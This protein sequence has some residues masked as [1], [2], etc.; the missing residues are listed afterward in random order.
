MIAKVIQNV[1]IEYGNAHL[2]WAIQGCGPPWR[3]SRLPGDSDGDESHR[4]ANCES[5]RLL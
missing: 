3:D 1:S 4:Q 2:L 5:R